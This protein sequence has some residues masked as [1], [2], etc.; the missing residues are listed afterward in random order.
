LGFAWYQKKLGW[1]YMLEFHRIEAQRLLE[2]V[3]KLDGVQT[4]LLEVGK[5]NEHLYA[6][7]TELFMYLTQLIERIDQMIGPSAI[8]C[9]PV[10]LN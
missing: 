9:K 8:A 5:M 2:A 7:Y 6:S 10:N 4:E 1:G 3:V